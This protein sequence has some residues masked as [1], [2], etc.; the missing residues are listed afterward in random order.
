MSATDL[1]RVELPGIEVNRKVENGI[2]TYFVQLDNQLGHL[3]ATFDPFTDIFDIEWFQTLV[4]RQGLGKLLLRKA[5]DLATEANAELI[6]GSIV[7][8]QS[9]DSVRSVFGEDSISVKRLGDYDQRN[10]SAVLYY[11]PKDHVTNLSGDL[12]TV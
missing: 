1:E 10:T 4:P 12:P 7:K 6:M 3:Q 8:R 5:L 9:L 11:Y 2:M